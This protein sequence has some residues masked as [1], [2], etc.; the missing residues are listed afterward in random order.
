MS[1]TEKLK[2]FIDIDFQP[3]GQLSAGLTCEFNVKFCPRINKDLEGELKFLASNGPFVIPIKCT[4]KKCDLSL[5]TNSVISLCVQIFY[6][7]IRCATNP[8]RP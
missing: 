1:I 6:I 7:I 2:D 5:S 8:K 4:V 3:P